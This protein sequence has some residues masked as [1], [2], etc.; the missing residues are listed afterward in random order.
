MSLASH[1]EENRLR[2]ETNDY[3]RVNI[4]KNAYEGRDVQ[5]FVPAPEG[6]D[7]TIGPGKR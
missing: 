4:E 5:G 1:R 2:P 6:E 7:V 3:Q